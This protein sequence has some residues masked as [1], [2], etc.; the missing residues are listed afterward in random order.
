MPSISQKVNGLHFNWIMN[1]LGMGSKVGLGIGEGCGY[2]SSYLI[3]TRY[4]I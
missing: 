1:M 2:G 4:L 3:F